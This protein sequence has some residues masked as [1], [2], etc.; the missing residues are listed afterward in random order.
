MNSINEIEID[1]AYCTCNDQPIPAVGPLREAYSEDF[2]ELWKVS[3]M[4]LPKGHIILRHTPS[5]V[6]NISS[7]MSAPAW[8]VVGK[9]SC[10][11]DE[12]PCW[13][14]RNTTTSPKK[15]TAAATYRHGGCFM[16]E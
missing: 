3:V 7:K 12:L 8:M 13:V 5:V 6:L 14:E 9:T 4:G 16:C 11:S 15:A 1:V 10:D 2:L